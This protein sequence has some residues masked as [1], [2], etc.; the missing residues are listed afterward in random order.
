MNARIVLLGLLTVLTLSAT[1]A[2][3]QVTPTSWLTAAERDYLKARG[4]LK[5]CV[6]PAWMPYERINDAGQHEGIAADYIQLLASRL[7]TPIVLHPTAN[8]TES[9][10]AIQARQCDLLSM[11]RELPERKRY[12]DFTRP[13]MTFPVVVA[14]SN[15]QMFIDHFESYLDK[16][17]AAPRGFAVISLLQERWPGLR[18]IEV[19]NALEGL[20]MVRRNEA[21]GYID[22]TLSISYTLASNGLLDLKISGRLDVNSAPGIATRNDQPILKRIFQKTLDTLSEQEKQEIYSRWVAIRYERGMDL[23]AYIE[24]IIAVA[25]LLLVTLYW[26][27]RLAS[28]NRIA[29]NALRELSLTKQQLESQNHQ[30]EAQ[31]KQLE[32]FANTDAL[33]GLANRARLDRILVAETERCRRQRTALGLI[34]L[35]IDHFKT[36]NDTWGHQVGDQALVDVAGL[37]YA[38]CGENEHAGRWGGEE[39]MIVCS[40]YDVERLRS[41]AERVRQRIEQHHFPQVEHMTASFGMV[42]LSETENIHSLINRADAALY[43]AKEQGR[44]RVELGLVTL[45]GEYQPDIDDRYLHISR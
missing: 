40:G 45:E 41:F 38:S 19:D 12:L 8:W 33:T 23:L 17:F 18:L 39:F 35:D 4:V 36:V 42:M 44:N 34:L 31:N 5:V 29:R 11:A 28:A 43:R 14:T 7:E 15:D 6:D 2:P 27:R 9:L 25:V 10:Q 24:I 26:N 13:Y 30:L 3:S 20:E 22:S 37:L 16:T 32:R 1:A 21:F